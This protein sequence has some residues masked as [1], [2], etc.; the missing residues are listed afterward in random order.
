MAKITK[1]YLNK[2]GFFI[3]NDKG[4]DDTIEDFIENPMMVSG[5]F[6]W[7]ATHEGS[8]YWDRVAEDGLDKK[9]LA[10][11]TKMFKVYHAEQ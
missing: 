8:L 10:T 6:Y 7:N 2:I 4:P 1:S 3:Q 9:S 11:L 5:A